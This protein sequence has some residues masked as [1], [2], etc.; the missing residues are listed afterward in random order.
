MEYIGL[1]LSERVTVTLDSPDDGIEGIVVG[2]NG[3]RADIY[4]AGRAT[5]VD[6]TQYDHAY[7]AVINQTR[8]PNE[9]G[10][11]TARYSVTVDAAADTLTPVDR[12]MAA[13]YFAAPVVT[14]TTDPEDVPLH[15]PFAQTEYNVRDE[16][17]TVDLP[18]SAIT[19]RGAP[20]GF[21]L[22]SVYG[23]NADEMDDEFRALNAPGGGTVVQMLYYNDAGQLIRITESPTIYV[24][25]GE[26]LAVNHL[27]F[28]P[29]TEIWTTGSVDAAIIDHNG[30]DLIAFIV[31]ERFMAID[32]DADRADMLD[33][34]R[35]FASSFGADR[36]LPDP[37]W[38]GQ[39][40]FGAPIR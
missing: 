17:R 18:F 32:G 23:V 10:C 8:P 36:E 15:S 30:D 28:K 7:L 29:G 24:T 31:Q 6:L 37:R 14:A 39:E 21:E 9:A 5:T 11:A 27:E 25:I 13:A 12:Q 19:P 35:R 2:V 20:E 16:I 4:P 26:W 1:A 38:P 3:T 33:M 34:A 22:D 40:S